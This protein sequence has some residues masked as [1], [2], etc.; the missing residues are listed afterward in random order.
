[1]VRLSNMDRRDLM[2]ALQTYPWFAA[3]RAML[4]VSMAGE[5][6]MDGAAGLF[7][8]SL[9]Y[10]PDSAYTYRQMRALHPAAYTDSKLTAAETEKSRERTRIYIAGTDFF[11]KEEY[12]SARSA[13]DSGISSIAVVDYSVP[14]P[15][16]QAR[17]HGDSFSLVSE[18]LARIYANQGYPERAK[19]I[20]LQL[21]L[22][23][24]EKS[25]Y[26]AS[27]IDNLNS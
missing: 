15:E 24:P 1:M 20:Y 26:F 7:R 16:P 6:G 21:S 25:A 19:E 9:A 17:T 4:C 27:L 13:E 10:L 23:S 22:E 5:E 8:E 12:E 2:A 18:T 3:A 11:S 14:V